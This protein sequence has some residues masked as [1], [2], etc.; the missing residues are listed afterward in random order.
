M[1]AE[2]ATLRINLTDRISSGV[3]RIRDALRGLGR[4]GAEAGR[5]ASTGLDRIKRA[6]QAAWSGLRR[7]DAAGSAM[8]QRLSG[9]LRGVLGLFRSWIPMLSAAAL[10]FAAI[11]QVRAGL[12]FN[13]D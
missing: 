2:D 13:K 7:V 6:A 12:E 9:G 1:P 3:G 8:T 10:G 5:E 11:T 4:G